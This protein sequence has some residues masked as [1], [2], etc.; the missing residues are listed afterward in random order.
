MERT[1]W[2]HDWELIIGGVILLAIGLVCLFFPNPTL[3]VLAILCGAG[4]LAAGISNIALWARM[5]KALGFAGWALAYG[6]IDVIVGLVFVIHPAITAVVLPWVAGALVLV[7][8]I[9]EAVASFNIRSLGFRIWGW[10]LASGI[11]SII[12]GILFFNVPEIFAI[13]LG[14]VAVMQGISLIVYG[15]VATRETDDIIDL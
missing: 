12:I 3:V 9:F 8:G 4:F 14:L 10:P 11:V 5:R 7:L 13:L 2:S 1:R 15:T 6:I